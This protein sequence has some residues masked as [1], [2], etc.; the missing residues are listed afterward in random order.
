MFWRRVEVYMNKKYV[1]KDRK[2]FYMF[3]ITVTVAL[4][5]I[6]FTAAVNGADFEEEKYETV[7]VQKGDTLWDLAEKYCRGTDIRQYIENI[8][9]VNDL[10]GDTIYEGDVIMMPVH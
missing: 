8:K 6:V 9:S 7:I 5:L 2:R 1:L 10:S 4:S 3:I